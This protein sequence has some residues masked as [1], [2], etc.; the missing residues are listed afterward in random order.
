MT[1]AVTS[2][3][4]SRLLVAENRFNC[5]ISNEMP[6]KSHMINR[7]LHS[8]SDAIDFIKLVAEKPHILHVSLSSTLINSIIHEHNT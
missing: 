5:K 2:L 4:T 6:V 7:I 8:C 3:T 1:Y